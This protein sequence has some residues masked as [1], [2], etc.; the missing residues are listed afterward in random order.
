MC[1][2]KVY[3]EEP[4]K[5]RME[6]ARNVIAAKKKDGT[7]LLGNALGAVILVNGASIE[8]ADVFSLE[9]TLRR[10]R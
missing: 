7:V 6:V 10:E 3:L 9:M 4:G 1:E 5:E 8:E 2:F